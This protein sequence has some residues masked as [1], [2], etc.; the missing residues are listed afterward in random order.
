MGDWVQSFA[1]VQ[2]PTVISPPASPVAVARESYGPITRIVLSAPTRVPGESFLGTA[3]VSVYVVGDLLIDAGAPRFASALIEALA[4]APPRRILLTHQHEDHA[5]GVPALRRAFGDIAVF[6][7]RPLLDL[8]AH[9]DVLDS[10]R[11]AYWGQPE[12]TPDLCPIEEGERFDTKGVTVEAVATPGHTPGHMSFMAR[13]GGRAYALSGDLL[14]SS[15]SY[16]GFFESCADDLTRSQR[17]V[18]GMGEGLHL[19]PAHGRTRPD[20]AAT[21]L[22]AAEWLAEESTTIRGAAAR[23]G[24][25]DPITVA[26]HLYGTPEPAELATGGDYSTAAL[27]RSVLAP[28]RSHPVPRLDV[29][30]AYPVQTP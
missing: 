9:P 7:P 22:R 5:G 20:G 28:I 29:R 4:D 2:C 23:L 8:I 30:A 18:A 14:I 17:Q 3:D 12:P 13:A 16:L 19:L 26:H 24:T 15:R 21:L 27:V 6:A 1:M 25:D 11:V 10:Y